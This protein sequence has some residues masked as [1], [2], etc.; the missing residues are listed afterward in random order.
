MVLG[1]TG[2]NFA[3]GMSG[4][5]AYVLDMQETFG[6]TSGMQDIQKSPNRAVS[7]KWFKVPASGVTKNLKMLQVE[8]VRMNNLSICLS[9]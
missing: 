5:V 4:G 3:A 7:P 1:Q 2:Q 8:S 9:S 6:S